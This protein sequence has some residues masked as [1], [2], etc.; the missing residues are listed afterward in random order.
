[1]N[2]LAFLRVP[3]SSV[4]LY[5]SSALP[6]APSKKYA[7]PTHKLAQSAETKS[8]LLRASQ[9]LLPVYIRPDFVLSHGKGPYVWDTEG[10]KYL[11]F[12]AG[13]AVNA[14]GHADD[15]VIKVPS[16]LLHLS[17]GVSTHMNRFLGDIRTVWKVASH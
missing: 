2:R 6:T 5:S 9:Y 13:I 15:G 1:M 17:C 8:F 4:R 3:H 12:S 10:N 11:D 14:L 7:E 16:L